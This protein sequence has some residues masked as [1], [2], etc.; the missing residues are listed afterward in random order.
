MIRRVSNILVLLTFAYWA[1]GLGECLHERFE[2]HHEKPQA[3][4]SG[5]RDSSK[6]L[7]EGDDHDDCVIC[8]TL[9]AMKAH[10]PTP[11]TLPEP[12]LPSVEIVPLPQPEA[13]VLAFV[14][15]IPA[16]APPSLSASD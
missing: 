13:P 16:R 8:Q 4:E 11:P 7:Q 2:H 10:Q 6:P 9:K 12:T 1:S 15:F 5:K 14:V 3:V